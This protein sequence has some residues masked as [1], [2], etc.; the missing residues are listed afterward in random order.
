MDEGLKIFKNDLM[1]AFTN[2]EGFS[3]SG[4]ARKFDRNYSL[5]EESPSNSRHDN[6]LINT[7]STNSTI[8]SSFGTDLNPNLIDDNLNIPPV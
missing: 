4:Y 5:F 2:H 6:Q 1:I 7:P 8:R 3:E